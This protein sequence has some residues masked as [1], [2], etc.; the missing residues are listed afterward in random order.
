MGCAPS[1]APPAP[2]G[3]ARAHAVHGAARSGPSGPQPP[4]TVAASATS[5]AAGLLTWRKSAVCNRH[6]QLFVVAL[7]N[8]SSAPLFL[9]EIRSRTALVMRARAAD[10]VFDF[11]DVRASPV[12]CNLL[13]ARTTGSDELHIALALLLGTTLL[14]EGRADLT[15]K[16]YGACEAMFGEALIASDQCQSPPNEAFTRNEAIVVSI[17]P[18]H[19]LGASRKVSERGGRG[20]SLTWRRRSGGSFSRGHGRGVAGGVKAR[21]SFSVQLMAPRGQLAINCAMICAASAGS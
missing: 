5:H 9:G 4:K 7:S 1:A 8:D 20:R 17:A 6:P 21:R 19:P 13:P 10:E 11:S 18:N 15:C 3:S 2:V 16:F 14:L 12:R